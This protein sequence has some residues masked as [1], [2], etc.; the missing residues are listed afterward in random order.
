MMYEYKYNLYCVLYCMIGNPY[1]LANCLK[2]WPFF[3][4]LRR[5]VLKRGRFFV[6]LPKTTVDKNMSQIKSKKVVSWLPCSSQT[7]MLTYKYNIILVNII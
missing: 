5:V 2:T 1:L 4:N 7:L 6:N 3:V